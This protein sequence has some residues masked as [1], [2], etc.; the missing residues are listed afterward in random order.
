MVG[1]P[2]VAVAAIRSMHSSEVRN[3]SRS[4]RSALAQLALMASVLPL[5]GAVQRGPTLHTSEVTEAARASTAPS[6]A[7]G[8]TIVD[9]VTH[10]AVGDN[11][12]DCGP[13]VAAAIRT[14]VGRNAK[15]G[16]GGII[17]FPP[18]LY[19]LAKP[20]TVPKNIY[21]VGETPIAS[22]IRYSGPRNVGA[23]ITFGKPGQIATF[24]GVRSLWVD[25]DGR[26][27]VTVL[28]HGPQ[29]GSEVAE[30]IATG[31]LQ[32]VI[33]VR[34]AGITGGSNKFVIERCWLWT[35]GNRGTAG[36]LLGA[37]SG[38]MSIRDTTMAGTNRNRDAPPNSAG[39]VALRSIVTMD[40][41]NVEAFESHS[42]LDRTQAE[43]R[44]A[45]GFSNRFGVK[46]SPQSNGTPLTLTNANFDQAENCVVDQGSGI[47]IR[48]CRTYWNEA[49]AHDRR[50]FRR[51]FWEIGSANVYQSDQAQVTMGFTSPATAETEMFK[52]TTL[53]PGG[54]RQSAT[55][56]K[57]GVFGTADSQYNGAHLRLGRYHLWVDRSGRLRMKE[58]SPLSDQDGTA[59]GG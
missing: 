58:G 20:L 24:S 38:P 5:Q 32:T 7:T 4:R 26:A 21:L 42:Y 36:V 29:E 27:D 52:F 49:Y 46:T 13:A 30:V 37:G 44:G 18:G 53:M 14:I 23:F 35:I 28:L 17:Y 31:A 12:T 6:T 9:V 51:N 45:T 56:D 22:R 1:P 33:E 54:W 16:A 15:S 19:A 41:V 2:E 47:T 3:V 57:A 8:L 55:I 48:Y 39:V 59:V 43:I 50:N 10:G 40:N 34:S 11:T 25:G